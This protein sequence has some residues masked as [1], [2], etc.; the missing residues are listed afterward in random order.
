MRMYTVFYQLFVKHKQ[1]LSFLTIIFVLLSGLDLYGQKTKSV[2]DTIILE[3]GLKGLGTY[4]LLE[5]DKKSV[6]H[7]PFEFAKSY[8]D[9][10]DNKYLK[11]YTYKGTYQQGLKQGNWIYEYDYLKPSSKRFISDLMI[12]QPGIGEQKLVTGHFSQ[13][14]ADKQWSVVSKS[15]DNGQTA[16]TL[17]YAKVVFENNKMFGPFMGKCDSI[18]VRGEIDENGFLHGTWTFIQQRHTGNIVSEHRTYEHGVLVKHFFELNKQSYEVK[19]VGLD[20]QFSNSSSDWEEVEVS[21]YYFNII[22]FTNVGVEKDLS[23]AKTN[24]LIQRSNA[25]LKTTLFSFG[26]HHDTPIWAMQKGGQNL[27]VPKLKVR[28]YPYQKGELKRLQTSQKLLN[29]SISNVEKYLQNPQVEIN[30]H[31]TLEIAKYYQVFKLSLQELIKIKKTID[32]LQLP[33]FEYINRQE[34]L[35][36]VHQKASLPA[37]IQFECNDSSMRSEFPFLGLSG[38]A[39]SNIEELYAFITQFHERINSA[40]DTVNP[41][42]ERNKTRAQIQDLEAALIQKKDSIMALFNNDYKSPDYNS[43]HQLFKQKMLHLA[44]EEFK[45]YSKRVV[46]ERVDLIPSKIA[47]FTSYVEFYYYLVRLQENRSQIAELYTRTVWNPFTFTDMQETVKER[48]YNA[49]YN[50]VLPFVLSELNRQLSCNEIEKGRVT[51]S[52]LFNRMKELR[53][54]DTKDLERAIRRA[55]EPSQLFNLLMNTNELESAN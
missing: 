29:E 2:T 40:L 5:G 8:E 15:I 49:Y 32:L 55:N 50:Q 43:F 26:F 21:Q 20:Q 48:V 3:N 19:H 47:C 10:V 35:P 11:H 7:G 4:H 34:I 14:L 22:Y 23:L 25:F 45:V 51:I 27:A 46:T 1:K 16:D 41:I 17:F 53:E 52:K 42:L 30:R 31:Y 12:L 13:G 6:L 36:Y 9:T 44:E 37:E 39:Q 18:Q 38:L 33:A 24:D 28:K 54:Q